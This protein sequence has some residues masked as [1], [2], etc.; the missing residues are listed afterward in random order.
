MTDAPLTALIIE[1]QPETRAWLVEVLAQAFGG[2]VASE[3]GD[4]AAGRRWLAAHDG[5]PALALIDLVLPD[6]SG[7]ELIRTISEVHPAVQPVVISMYDDD[8]HLFDAIAAGAQGYLLKDEG[9]TVLAGRLKEILNG[10]PPLSPSIARRILS[11]FH[12]GA[13]Q[14]EQDGVLT[15]REQEVLALLGKG[16]RIGDAAGVLGLTRHTVAGYVKL[17]YSKL[18]ITSRAQ[19]ALEARRRG[20]V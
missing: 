16:L 5:R 10:E 18:N 13:S 6:G 20:L 8:A 9:P 19:A 4:V 2:L 1:D 14:F 12:K 11:H 7:V 3:G 15:P 17:I